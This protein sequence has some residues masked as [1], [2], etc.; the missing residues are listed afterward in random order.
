M[1]S[2]WPINDYQ[3]T[4]IAEIADN[5]GMLRNCVRPLCGPSN[6]PSFFARKLN[7]SRPASN[8]RWRRVTDGLLT[9]ELG[10]G[11]G[12]RDVPVAGSLETPVRTARRM[13][14]RSAEG[15]YRSSVNAR[16][17]QNST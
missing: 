13:S 17:P 1:E 5:I 7:V 11:T 9:V 15:K 16:E 14:I 3:P 4:G 8:H 12:T 10:S 6:F 2:Q